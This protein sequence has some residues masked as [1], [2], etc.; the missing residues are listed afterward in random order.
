MIIVAESGSSKT[1]WCLITDQGKVA[2]VLSMG[3]NPMLMG[4][5]Q[6]VS[7]MLKSDLVQWRNER[8]RRLYFYGAGCSSVA[9]KNR[10]AD[11]L[12][13]VFNADLTYIEHDL[14]GACRALFGQTT[15]VAC[16]LG[17]GSNSCL[18]NGRDI[19][20]NVPALGHILGDEGGGMDIGRRLL[21]AYLKGIMPNDLGH[22][23]A[24][25]YPYSVAE[26]LGE[27][28]GQSRPNR[29]IAAFALFAKTHEDHPFVGQLIE[30]AFEDFVVKNINQYA[31]A[32]ALPIGF[33]GSIAFQFKSQLRRV[34][35]RHD[36]Q[37]G[38]VL[39][40]PVKQLVDFHLNEQ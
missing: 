21:V 23:F 40:R 18:Y 35:N 17:T 36:L 25:K 34:L 37:L 3:F 6:M 39:D 26:F 9:M 2:H 28:Y 24:Q 16:I 11:A 15:G 1:D 30:E 8:V 33:V 5:D 7:E 27:V 10:V 22:Q 14:L 20:E 32:R 31:Q 19:V 13:K 12:N 38:Q 29:F 4:K